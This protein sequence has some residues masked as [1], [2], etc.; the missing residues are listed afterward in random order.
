MIGTGKDE[1]LSDAERKEDKLW[2]LAKKFMTTEEG[3][4]EVNNLEQT[5]IKEGDKILI[6]KE[7]LSIL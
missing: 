2:D 6:F 5:T 4:M 1:D 3:I 7:N